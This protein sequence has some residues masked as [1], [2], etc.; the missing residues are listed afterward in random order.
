M[1]Q[2][3]DDLAPNPLK[4][5]RLL[6]R[7]CADGTVLDALP[8]ALRP[9][10]E[11]QGHAIQAL[12]PQAAGQ[13]VVGWKIAATSV[14]GQTHIQVD[15]PLAGRIL[16]GGVVRAGERPSLVGNRMRVAE[17]EFAFC[18]GR[19]LP[20]RTAPYAQAEVMAAV[21]SLHPALE[22]PDS[23]FADFT[24]AGKAQLIADNA[25]CG[26]FLFGPAAPALWRDIDLATHA[27]AAQVRG[28]QGDVRLQRDG[29]G[30]AALG[31]P[32]TAL[33]WLA[34]EL[35]GLGLALPAGSVVSTGTCMQPLAI[36]PGDQVQ[37]DFGAL[38]SVSL[39]LA[40]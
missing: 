2:H 35:S 40:A 28:V 30:A 11:A 38:G 6:W 19:D 7:H 4:A 17:P 9:A 13:P 39:H 18:M 26:P 32:R 34:N 8:P 23:R 5:A 24:R 25:C 29:T 15:G 1:T 27:V 36:H 14:A 10:N 16:A 37:A 22:L 3:H 21:A 33:V 20:P 12:W 31:D